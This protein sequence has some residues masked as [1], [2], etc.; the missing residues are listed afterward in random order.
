M[1]RVGEGPISGM[2]QGPEPVLP[3]RRGGVAA[4]AD[5][6]RQ[7]GTVT[8]RDTTARDT[9]ARDTTALDTTALDTTALDTTARDT[10][11]RDTAARDTG[12]GGVAALAARQE[13]ALARRVR[14]RALA[15]GT[16]PEK[17]AA[18]I[19]AECGPAFG[20]TLIRAHR[21]ALGIALG[22]VVAQ[23]QAWY[24]ADGRRLPRFSETLLSAYE[25]GQK[26]PGAEYLHYLCAVYRAD[27]Q[28]LG[29]QARCLCG[30]GHR[31]AASVGTQ[32]GTASVAANGSAVLRRESQHGRGA[33]AESAAPPGTGPY[34]TRPAGT[35][36]AGTGLAGTGLA[37][38]GPAGT[39]SVVVAPGQVAQAGE[40]PDSEKDDDVLRRMLAGLLARP[41]ADLDSAFLGAVDRIRRRMDD[42]LLAGRVSATLLDRWEESAAGYARQYMTAPPLRLLCDTLLDFGDVR[43]MCAERQSVE[44]AERLCGLAGRFAGLA[45]IVMIDMGD[46]RLARS[47]FRTARTAVDETGDRRLRAWVAAREALVPLYYG[48]PGEALTLAGSAVDLAG[49]NPCVASVMASAVAARALARMAGRGRRDALEQAIRMLDRAHDGLDSLPEPDRADTAFGYTQ[50]QLYFYEGDA[51]VTLG[52]CQRAERALT[53]A[54]R[55]YPSGELLDRALVTLGL[56]RCLLEA[57][58]PEQ[59]LGL[60]RDALLGLPREHRPQLVLRTA[61]QLGRSAAE[62]HAGLPAL[63]EYREAVL[64]G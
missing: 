57:G 60:S 38:M 11:A 36:L 30:A 40:A 19:R 29:Y 61:G 25:S 48:D 17:I 45:G 7:R 37:G 34:G 14:A 9:T 51:L 15:A 35:G 53:R 18:Q 47:F 1:V 49:R 59:A 5:R 8:A 64:T 62:R 3:G 55:L 32:D 43:R 31:D 6:G 56:A 24:Q 12:T 46:Q 33:R 20:T 42:A 54:L 44:S 27:P 58:E 16:A 63:Q 50:R 10:A 4:A 21:L 52:D 2:G 22:D 26:R 39:G 23:V 13:L 41:H 28:D